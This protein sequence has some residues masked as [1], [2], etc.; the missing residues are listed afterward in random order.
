LLLMAA[1]AFVTLCVV[2]L[3]PAEKTPGIGRDEPAPRAAD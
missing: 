3:L 2:L 1:I